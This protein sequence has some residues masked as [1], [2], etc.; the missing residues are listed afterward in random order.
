MQ[1]QSEE[2][3]ERKRGNRLQ[4]WGLIGTAI[5]AIILIVV[6]AMGPRYGW[7]TLGPL[8]LNELGDFL[9]G[10]FGPLSIFWL[11]LGFF[12][13]G[14]ELR[15]QVTELARSVE[16][17]KELVGV[18]RETLDHERQ[19]QDMR[20]AAR[21]AALQ[22]RFLINCATVRNSVGGLIANVRSHLIEITNVGHSVSGV[23]VDFVPVP[24]SSSD[25]SRPYFRNGELWK[26][27]LDYY[28]REIPTRGTMR[29]GYS[30][31]DGTRHEIDYSYVGDGIFDLNFVEQRR[32]ELSREGS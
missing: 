14:S 3:L 18:S 13:Q 19:L 32:S 1:D 12:Q 23:T 28:D 2:A 6:F 8:D 24:S 16:Q 7:I 31:E 9:A 15:L 5:Y 20:E 11:V 10:V 17:Q 29:I 22:P 25:Y 27:E 30:D 21:K 4:T 26:L